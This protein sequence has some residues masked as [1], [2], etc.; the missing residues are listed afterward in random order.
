[1]K[2]ASR[3]I[4]TALVLLTTAAVVAQESQPVAAQ[5]KDMLSEGLDEARHASADADDRIEAMLRK[6]LGRRGPE[7]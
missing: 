7:G 2:R 6:L 4:T 1:V 5:S 3:I